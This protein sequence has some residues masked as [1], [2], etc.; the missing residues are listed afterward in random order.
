MRD[1][2]LILI[3]YTVD[4]WTTWEL[5]AF[6]PYTV[7]IS[8]NNFWLLKILTTVSLQHWFQDILQIPKSVDTQVPYLKWYRTM[9]TVGLLQLPTPNCGLKMVYLIIHW[10]NL[11]MQNPWTWR[12]T[13]FSRK[14]LPISGLM[15]FKPMLFRGKPKINNCKLLIAKI[16][17]LTIE[18]TT[19]IIFRNK[20]NQKCKGFICWE[21]QNCD[22]RIQRKNKYMDRYAMFM[23]WKTQ[24]I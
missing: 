3:L 13:V 4:H 15:Q 20:F 8:V 18:T 17:L 23:D 21:L 19:Y 2:K 6:T 22:D 5:G 1:V 7:K 14:N 16:V 11:W 24:Y 9:P 12:T 10:L